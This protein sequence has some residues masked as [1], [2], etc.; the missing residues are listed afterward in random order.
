MRSAADG[1]PRVGISA[2]LL[3]ERVR[4]DGRDKRTA[5]IVEGLG[6]HVEWV[7]VCP[8]VEA[9]LGV[10]RPAMRLEQASGGLRLVEIDGGRDH[11]ERMREHAAGRVLALRALELCGYVLKTRSPSCGIHGVPLHRHGARWRPEGRG[12]FAAALIEAYA[13]LPMADEEELA[14]PARLAAFLARVVAYGGQ[15]DR[16]A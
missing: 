15:R 14:D 12:L 7:S 9:G 5:H 4:Y 13:A 2:C 1:L 16:S 3:G 8:E 6:P 10:P 11:T